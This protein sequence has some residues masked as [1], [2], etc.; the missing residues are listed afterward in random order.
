MIP[1]P[2]RQDTPLPR[3][4]GAPAAMGPAL[5]PRF[6]HPV[7]SPR[8][9]ITEPR[10]RHP[11]FDDR[12]ADGTGGLNSAA[13]VHPLA[14]AAPAPS[15]D[16]IPC[17]VDDGMPAG[18]AVPGRGVGGMHALQDQKQDGPKEAENAHH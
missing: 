1:S 5:R 4:V 9:V 13:A 18:E 17:G 8:R 10:A 14:P 11:R 7:F 2:P 3:F 6:A 16:S 12:L 15:A